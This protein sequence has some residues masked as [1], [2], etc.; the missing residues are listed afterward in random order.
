MQNKCGCLQF[1]IFKTFFAKL[2]RL[3]LVPLLLNS[4][5]KL[6]AYIAALFVN[7]VNRLLSVRGREGRA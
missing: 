7:S 3:Y 5:G 2:C 4:I 1:F 6:L